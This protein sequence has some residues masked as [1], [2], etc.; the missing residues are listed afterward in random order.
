ME[1]F[2]NNFEKEKPTAQ[3]LAYKFERFIRGTIAQGAQESLNNLS[4]V[5]SPEGVY[6]DQYSPNTLC[7][8]LISQSGCLYLVTATID[9]ESENLS[10]Y[11]FQAVS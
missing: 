9:N 6:F 3:Q 4:F 11:R 8:L 2:K 10:N 5:N 7:C 1:T